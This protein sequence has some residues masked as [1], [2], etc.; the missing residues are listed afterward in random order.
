M[1]SDHCMKY[2]GARLVGRGWRAVSLQDG[3][4][5]IQMKPDVISS[6]D[7]TSGEPQ[8]WLNVASVPKPSV[9][10]LSQHSKRLQR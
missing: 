8:V 2:S 7:D 5:G 3:R 9:D 6:Q 1:A 10:A 4:K